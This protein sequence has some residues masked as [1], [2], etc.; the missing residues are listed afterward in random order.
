[1]SFQSL[2]D[3]EFHK[4]LVCSVEAERGGGK[5]AFGVFSVVSRPPVYI[6][7]SD[8]AS[9]GV[10]VDAKKVGFEDQILVENYVLDEVREMVEEIDTVAIAKSD[11]DSAK[12]HKRRK[13]EEIADTVKSAATEVFAQFSEDYDKAL[14]S[15]GTVVWDTASEVYVL[16]RLA[17]L[18]RIKQ[19]PAIY[20]DK[21]N[22]TMDSMINK[23][24][25]NPAGTSLV[26]LHKLKD[27][28]L[29][30]DEGKNGRTGRMERAGYPDVE[31]PAHAMVRL[32]NKGGRSDPDRLPR[33]P[34]PVP[35]IPGEWHM[36]ILKCNAKGE[37]VGK[38]YL[39]DDQMMGF[40]ILGQEI[41]GEDW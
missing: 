1:M 38:D 19:I 3:M 23:A 11:S 8:F 25:F 39:I 7:R 16:V 17:I 9:E 28:W 33:S 32:Y 30:D 5:S 22:K 6:Q 37:L 14:E 20:Y 36:R 40:T 18:G 10:L 27:E 41:Y 15:G 31:Y 24:V 34:H 29:K 26:M 4:N 13:Q 12:Q 35:Q 21:V 2:A